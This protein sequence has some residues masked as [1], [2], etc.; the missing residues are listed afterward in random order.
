M[1]YAMGERENIKQTKSN[2]RETNIFLFQ[3][4]NKSRGTASGKIIHTY[5]H[6]Y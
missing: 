4:K 3:S 1:N 2:Y 5:F 6:T